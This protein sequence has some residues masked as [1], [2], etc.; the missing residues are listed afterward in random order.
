MTGLV[1]LKTNLLTLLAVCTL[2]LTGCGDLAEIQDR[3]F[4]LALGIS[5]D[6][7]NYRFTY[8]LPDLGTVTGQAHSTDNS[9]L[10]R[11]YSG[12]SLREIEQSYNFSS[13]KRLDYRHLQVIILDSSI[14][15]K[16]AAMKELLIQMN[17]YYDISHNVLVYYYE[18]DVRKLLHTEGVNGSIGEH[19]NRMNKNNSVSGQQPAKIGDLID[20]M[21]NERTLYIPA[22][23]S[24]E[25]SLFVDGGIFFQNNQIKRS[26]SRSESSFFTI[27]AGK[28]SDHLIRTAL[29]HLVQLEN[30]KVKTRYELSG[31]G[32]NISLHITG[33]ARILP[34]AGA[35]VNISQTRDEINGEIKSGIEMM[36]DDMMKRDHIDFL[37]LYEQSSYKSR[38]TWLRYRNQTADFIHDSRIFVTVE[39]NYQ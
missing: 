12:K 26:V 13:A 2:L 8:C 31:S 37:N 24:R 33:S 14:C 22:L 7:E 36:L 4:V 34:E 19:L 15:L 6:D 27:A 9:S 20:S 21:E 25:N 10:L 18:A 29:G 38:R 39:L 35:A 17:D 5:Y 1:R 28:S 3:D 23:A 16:P 32:P 11:T 30:I